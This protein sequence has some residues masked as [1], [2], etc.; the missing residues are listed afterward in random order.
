MTTDF[1]GAM[2]VMG[3]FPPVACDVEARPATVLTSSTGAAQGV[4]H[5]PPYFAQGTVWVRIEITG[6]KIWLIGSWP[7]SAK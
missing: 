7:K 6:E 4:N 5:A 1:M 3:R 2:L